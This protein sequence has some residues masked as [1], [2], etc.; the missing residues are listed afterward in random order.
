[1]SAPII[2]A[3]LVLGIAVR[4][5]RQIVPDLVMVTCLTI[6]RALRLTMVTPNAGM[7]FRWCCSMG[8]GCV[9]PPPQPEPRGY[10]QA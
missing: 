8:S 6:V 9:P 4:V 2:V 5:T 10:G 3:V 1:M 7:P